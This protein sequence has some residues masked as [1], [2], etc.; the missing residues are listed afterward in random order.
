MKEAVACCLPM[1]NPFAGLAETSLT[2][3]PVVRSATAC[4]ATIVSSTGDSETLPPPS[5]TCGLPVSA[6]AGNDRLDAARA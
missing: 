3:A 6:L 5:T 1:K 4:S 2:P